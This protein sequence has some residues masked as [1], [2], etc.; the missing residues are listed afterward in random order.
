MRIPK[1]ER[2]YL[3]KV[4]EEEDVFPF[5]LAGN[6]KNPAR[7]PMADRDPRGTGPESEAG[8]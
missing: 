7:V 5:F 3:I 8:A 4:E 2:T 6:Q 1:G